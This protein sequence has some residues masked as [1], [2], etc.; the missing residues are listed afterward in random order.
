VL[1]LTA[2]FNAERRYKL[3]NGHFFICPGPCDINSINNNL[4][5]IINDPYFDY[6]ITDNGAGG[7]SATATRK[8]SPLCGGMTMIVSDAS[9]TVV[10]N[11]NVW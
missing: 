3:D 10:K 5:V 7:F 11:C 6:S 9:S 2:L 8:D 1:N 4:S